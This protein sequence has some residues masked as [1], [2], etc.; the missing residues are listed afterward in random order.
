MRKRASAATP[1]KVILERPAPA[2]L[3]P[4]SVQIAFKWR[5]SHLALSPL[6]IELR[7]SLA[8]E[9]AAKRQ[10]R[11][12]LFVANGSH[13]AKS[14]VGAASSASMALLRSFADLPFAIYKYAAPL[15][16]GKAPLP[17]NSLALY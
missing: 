8:N 10:L 5:R 3:I 9:E 1:P 6:T 2:R 12:G 11:S 16:L 14:P 15:G 4:I 13:K 7:D 17:L